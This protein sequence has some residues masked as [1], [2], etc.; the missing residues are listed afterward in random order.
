[1]L[2][3]NVHVFPVGRVES[4]DLVRDGGPVARV[5]GI[6]CRE[7]GEVDSRGFH[8]DAHGLFT[9]G[10][11]H[12]TSD[13]TG[14]EGDRVHYMALGGRH[15]ISNGRRAAGR[16]P[17]LRLAAGQGAARDGAARLHAGAC[18]RHGAGSAAIRR[19]RFRPLDRAIARSDGVHQGRAAQRAA[20]RPA[21]KTHRQASGRQFARALE[22][23]R[24][25]AAGESIAA[26]RA[27]GR[28][29]HRSAAEIW[30]RQA[31]GLERVAGMRFAAE[32]AAP[33]GTTRKRCS[34]TSYGRCGRAS[35]MNGFRSI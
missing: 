19:H 4:L 28:T 9:I 34:A 35:R 30:A 12:G 13:S 8:R 22:D 10:V 24:H 23:R 7:N 27:G 3:D 29:A 21:G 11:A 17:L 1:M 15:Q 20:C 18:R 32:R 2:P 26:R 16:R 25:G 14:R 33:N 5:Q 31:A 6:S